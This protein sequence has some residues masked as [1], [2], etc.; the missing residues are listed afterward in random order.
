MVRPRY[1]EVDNDAIDLLNKAQKLLKK[2][3]K[4][5][6]MEHDGKKVPH[7]AADGKGHKDEKKKAAKCPH[8]DGDAAKSKCICGK[9]EKEEKCPSCG[10]KKSACL[11]KMGC[12]MKKYGEMKKAN[13]N[14]ITTF[15]TEPQDVTFVA[16]SGGQTRNAYYT[17]NQHLLDS[18]DV[19]N[20]GATSYAYNLDTLSPTV[21]T[22]DRP[23]ESHE[24]TSG[25]ESKTNE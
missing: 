21:N 17:S 15:S 16:E 20:K 6:M 25:G 14:F 23:F 24:I 8:C 22:H 19:A 7:F 11:N 3:E 1:S 12:G 13:P 5:Q 9:V 4:L 18:E 2:A 10:M